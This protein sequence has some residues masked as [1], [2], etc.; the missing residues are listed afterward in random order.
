MF[1]QIFNEGAQYTTSII[2]DKTN[3]VT[4]LN[5]LIDKLFIIGYLL[6]ISPRFQL[7]Q[8][9]PELSTFLNFSI[10]FSLKIYTKSSFITMKLPNL[11]KVLGTSL[12]LHDL[13][14]I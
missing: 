2:L 6:T 3:I 5:E 1:F 13:N 10:K 12:I 4:K 8:S 7:G 11:L 14:Y 9:N